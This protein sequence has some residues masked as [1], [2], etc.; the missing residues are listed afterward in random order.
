MVVSS[1]ELYSVYV[2]H[3]N[4]VWGSSFLED[5]SNLTEDNILKLFFEYGTHLFNIATFGYT[6]HQNVFFE[7]GYESS[8]YNDFMKKGTKSDWG[9]CCHNNYLYSTLIPQFSH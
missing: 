4:V 7:S 8:S 9:T 2:D 5:I 6:C 1:R 3:D